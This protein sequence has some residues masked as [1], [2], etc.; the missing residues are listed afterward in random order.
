MPHLSKCNIPQSSQSEMK[1]KSIEKLISEENNRQHRKSRNF[2][3]QEGYYSHSPQTDKI[4]NILVK[5]CMRTH[6]QSK[7]NSQSIWEHL[8]NISFQLLEKKIK[9]M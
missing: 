8:Y 1:L 9:S 7:N 3:I 2:L 5:N 4:S 6:R